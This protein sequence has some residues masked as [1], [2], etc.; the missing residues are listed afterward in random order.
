MG[1]DFLRPAETRVATGDT[2][3]WKWLG[4]AGDHSVTADPGQAESFD[5]DPGKAPSAIA[6]PA[7][8]TFTHRFTQTGRFTY[9]CRVHPAMTGE[10][11]VI[12]LPPRD[13]KRPALSKLS[14][15]PG[16]VCP[17]STSRCRATRA[18]V[19][20]S[21]SEPATVVGRMDR[22][23]AAVESRAD[24]RLRRAQGPRAPPPLRARPRARAL[25]APA[26]G[27]RLRQ[28]PLALEAGALPGRP[29]VSEAGR[30]AAV[31]GGLVSAV[32]LA[33]QR[34]GRRERRALGRRARDDRQHEARGARAAERDRVLRVALVDRVEVPARAVAARRPG[35]SPGSAS[36]ARNA[37][38]TG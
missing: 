7:G 33:A 28:Q 38:A 31:R 2:V 14:V 21:L 34:G 25:P 22:A 30:S 35:R 37:C 29:A 20:L 5:S 23:A 9:R 1:D 3:V 17:R 11:T 6:H 12:A 24:V 13:V 18:Y 8:F 27:L 26:G 32:G 19:H 36:P 10:V 15:R 16:R 4:P